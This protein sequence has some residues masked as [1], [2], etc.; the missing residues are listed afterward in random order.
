MSQDER[1]GPIERIKEKLGHGSG[2][3]VD[4]IEIERLSLTDTTDAD[5]IDAPP[6]TG[7]EE[8]EL[9][10]DLRNSGKP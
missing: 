3:D 2:D 1:G 5:R 10:P 7:L 6:G 8:D 4:P 9:P